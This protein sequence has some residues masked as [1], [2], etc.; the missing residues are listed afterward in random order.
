V[1]LEPFDQFLRDTLVEDLERSQHVGPQPCHQRLEETVCLILV[2]LLGSGTGRS[3]H[4]PSASIK[5]Q[6]VLELL[7]P[8]GQLEEDF[9]GELL[10]LEVRRLERL[11]E[12]E[13]EVSW[14]LCR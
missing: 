12:V 5:T 10:I 14:W 4:F 7:V 8:M 13:V 1:S 3:P 6:G 2:Y 9:I 11:E